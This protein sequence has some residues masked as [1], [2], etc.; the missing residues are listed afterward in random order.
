[1]D[2]GIDLP[3]RWQLKDAMLEQPIKHTKKIR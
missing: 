1:V 3:K 2:G